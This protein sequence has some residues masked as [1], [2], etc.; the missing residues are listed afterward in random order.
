LDLQKG[1]LSQFGTRSIGVD[2]FFKLLK[3]KTF[4]S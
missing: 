1:I 2:R 3:T 4:I